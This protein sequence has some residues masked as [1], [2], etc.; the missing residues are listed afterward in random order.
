M[1]QPSPREQAQKMKEQKIE[2][3][4]GGLVKHGNR[5]KSDEF[6]ENLEHLG[7]SK[8]K[9]RKLMPDLGYRREK[10]GFGPDGGWWVI[11]D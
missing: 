5:M 10:D 4:L 2:E 7:F 9:V 3:W 8:R 11:R 1:A 6:N